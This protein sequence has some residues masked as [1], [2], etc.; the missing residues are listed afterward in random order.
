MKSNNLVFGI[1]IVSIFLACANPTFAASD[2]E[3]EWYDLSTKAIEAGNNKKFDEKE[4]Y[5][6]Q[7][8]TLAE[9]LGDDND[10]LISS[11]RD[12]GFCLYE[13]GSYDTAEPLLTR[14]LSLCE[15]KYGLNSPASV[16]CLNMLGRMKRH[17][18]KQEEA[19]KYASEA[20]SYTHL[21]L[22]TKRI[23]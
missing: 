15:K 4:A 17:Q 14:A 1:A 3:N 20:V 7:A 9:S 21:T 18:E 13:K 22:P 19:L 6:K 11:V 2:K 12:L 23:V 10:M 8:L 5:L 16:A